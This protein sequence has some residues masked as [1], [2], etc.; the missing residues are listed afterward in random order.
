MFCQRQGESQE[1]FCCSRASNQGEE[2]GVEEIQE[3]MGWASLS[4]NAVERKMFTRRILLYCSSTNKPFSQSEKTVAGYKS[5]AY[6][7]SYTQSVVSWTWKEYFNPW[8]WPL[9]LFLPLQFYLY[10]NL[11]EFCT[12]QRWIC[13]CSDMSLK[14]SCNEIRRY[15]GPE[16]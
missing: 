10:V 15:V 5:T 3:V 6:A 8:S 7:F 1:G 14:L 12:S 13:G 4:A 11:F 9:V 16:E 2:R